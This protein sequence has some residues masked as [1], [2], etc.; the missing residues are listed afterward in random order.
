MPSVGKRCHELRIPDENRS[1]RIIYRVDVDAIVIL[2]V[3]EKKTQKTPQPVIDVC[4]DRI[5][6]YD[7]R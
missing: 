6:R 5:R 1:W 4:K 2:H 7:G 3:F